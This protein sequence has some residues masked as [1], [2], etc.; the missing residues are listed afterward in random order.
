MLCFWLLVIVVSF[1]EEPVA[2]L[3]RA[4]IVR[5]LLDGSGDESFSFTAGSK[6]WKD[7]VAESSSSEESSSILK[8]VLSFVFRSSSKS[9]IRLVYAGETVVVVVFLEGDLVV[10]L[11]KRVLMND[12][13]KLS[14]TSLWN[15][16]FRIS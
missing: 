6:V 5:L 8:R 10:S 11:I 1:S 3:G 15:C 2:V 12:S 4:F 16:K 9:C 14:G 13:F 7:F